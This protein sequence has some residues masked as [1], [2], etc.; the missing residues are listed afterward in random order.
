MFWHEI[1]R[2]FSIFQRYQYLT[3]GICD[4]AG[5]DH[6]TLVTYTNL[7]MKRP[8]FL[9][10]ANEPISKIGSTCC[11]IYSANEKSRLCCCCSWKDIV[12]W[13]KPSVFDWPALGKCPNPNGNFRWLSFVG[14]VLLFVILNQWCSLSSFDVFYIYIFFVEKIRPYKSFMKD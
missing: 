1:R 14:F 3:S 4:K 13:A 9:W 7:E 6:I 10:H 8:N 12:S 2:I 5:G 11:R